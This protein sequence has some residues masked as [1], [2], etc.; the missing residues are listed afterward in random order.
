MTSSL[1]VNKLFQFELAR[2]VRKCLEQ[3]TDEQQREAIQMVLDRK[4]VLKYRT[5]GEY[6]WTL[7]HQA[8][9]NGCKTFLDGIFVNDEVI[10]VYLVFNLTH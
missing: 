10:Y 2:K 8:A 6:N 3:K 4:E 9:E 5:S 7:L 1:T